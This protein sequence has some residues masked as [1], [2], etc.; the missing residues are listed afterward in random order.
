MSRKKKKILPSPKLKKKQKKKLVISTNAILPFPAHQSSR[1]G[2]ASFAKE[3]K[4]R[5]NWKSFRLEI[6]GEGGPSSPSR[7]RK[8][9]ILAMRQ[10]ARIRRRYTLIFVLGLS[11]ASDILSRSFHLPTRN[12]MGS[13]EYFWQDFS[14]I[15]SRA[16][17]KSNDYRALNYEENCNVYPSRCRRKR[18]STRGENFA[19]TFSLCLSCFLIFSFAPPRLI[20]PSF[21]SDISTARTVQNGSSRSRCMYIRDTRTILTR[22][23]R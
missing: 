8:W 2:Y 1:I 17:N 20:V 19:V 4:K 7:G 10:N 16:R 15:I 11:R 18:E 22:R 23:V 12:T 5:V 3:K 9:N 14:S 13:I 6:L 21:F